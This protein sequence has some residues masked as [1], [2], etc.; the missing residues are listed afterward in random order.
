M[1]PKTGLADPYFLIWLVQTFN[2]V[3]GQTNINTAQIAAIQA[4][5]AAVASAQAAAAAAA[6]SAANAQNTADGGGGSPTAR[7]GNATSVFNVGFGWSMGPQVNLLTVSAGDLTILGSQPTQT[8]TTDVSP[9]GTFDGEW[10]IVEIVGFVETTVF[11]GQFQVVKSFDGEFGVTLI[12]LY[13]LTDTSAVVIPQVSTGSVS[14]RM[15][16]QMLTG[17]S[18]FDVQCNLFV[19]RA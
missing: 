8:A 11:T 2:A 14:Y 18:I 17:V 12:T 1:D 7:T 4:L 13:N 16:L 5:N 10:R 3:I 19:R 9:Q 6:Q 15:D